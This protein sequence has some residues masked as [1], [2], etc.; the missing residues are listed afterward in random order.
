M[1]IGV[2]GAIGSGKSLV[3]SL[4]GELL[5]APVYSSDEIC[6]QLLEKGETGYFQF[7]GTWGHRFLK[8][9][10]EIDRVLLR[11]AVF[12]DDDIRHKLETILHPLV[13]LTLLD[14]KRNKPSQTIQIAEVP[15]LFESGWQADFDGVI[16][17][18]AEREAILRRV[19]ARDA[20]KRAEVEKILDL[21]M[22]P[23]LKAQKSDWVVD[24]SGTAA[25]TRNQVERLID[26]LH[27]LA[28]GDNSQ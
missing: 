9:S 7:V 6:R 15:L 25:Q 19:V 28:S 2:T 3:A 4:L 8:D 17:V 11:T 22:D 24:N 10:G 18:A 23:A 20:V 1:L 27:N 14:L 16:C 5:P 21:Q 13:R 26:T 12:A